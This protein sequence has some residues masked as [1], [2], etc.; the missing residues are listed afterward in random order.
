[1]SLLTQIYTVSMTVTVSEILDLDVVQ[2][3][4]PLVLSDEGVER[5]V[6]WVHSIDIED[7]T[8]LLRG[9]ELVLTTGVALRRDAAR[10]LR[11][12]AEAGAVGVLVE[13]PVPEG[14]DR[15]DVMPDG[16]PELAR[17]LG[18]TLVA[19][20]REVRF[21][22]ITE[23]VHRRLVAQ[24]YEEVQFARR[25]YETFTD[26]AMHREPPRGIVATSAELLGAPV[27]LE[28]PMHRAVAVAGAGRPLDDLLKGWDATAREQDGDGRSSWASVDVGPVEE[29]WAR[30]VA[31][32]A[33]LP[34]AR[35]EMVLGRAAQALHLQ[36]MQEYG[37]QELEHRA[38]RDLF[39]DVLEGRL[40][41]G[42]I[43]A[44]AVALGM[45]RADQYVAVTAV[46]PSGL[47]RERRGID[48]EPDGGLSLQHR[49]RDVLAATVRSQGHTGLVSLGREARVDL[50][51]A[52][53]HG[54]EVPGSV[55]ERLGQA[56]RTQLSRTTGLDGLVAGFADPSEDVFRAVLATRVSA[57]A[58]AAAAALRAPDHVCFS[59]S[60]L[61][62]R[63]LSS[64]IR[65]DPRVQRFAEAEL[66]PLLLDDIRRE[67]RSVDVLRAYLECG[68]N[69]TA[70]AQRL[71]MSRPALYAHLRRIVET[72]GVSLED[73]E[74]RASLHVALMIIDA[75]S[76]LDG[77]EQ[78]GDLLADV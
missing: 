62:L 14:G 15:R 10:H 35:V 33:E 41:S 67:G 17:S 39:D 72:L 13:R 59:F 8:H 24:Q 4:D 37:G 58:A 50:V 42:E 49:M 31:V 78:S 26:L 30:L 9:G 16:V 55:L 27:V 73:G 43:E 56:M 52:L 32:D 70:V 77:H 74:S 38:H 69:K 64:L 61:R 29:P 28:D 75:R 21:V 7:V 1:M 57:Q 18:L 63:G 68:G 20:R 66:G 76:A 11:G 5:A 47:N 3:G 25:V 48:P 65:D 46:V 23:Q 34:S 19:L 54:Q 44:R 53:Q 12:L 36:R 22:E 71:H 40:T 6:R 2:A 60:G 45:A 51:L